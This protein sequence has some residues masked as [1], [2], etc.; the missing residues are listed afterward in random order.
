MLRVL[1][2]LLLSSALVAQEPAGEESSN[3]SGAASAGLIFVTGNN[4]STISSADLSTK[5]EVPGQRWIF[6]AKYAAVRQTDPVTS[7]ASTSSRLYRGAVEH[8]RFLDD[9][10]NLYLYGKGSAFRNVPTGLQVREDLGLGAGYTWRWKDGDAQFSL[11]GGPSALKENLVLLPAGDTALNGRA[12][13]GYENKISDDLKATFKA[14]FF[15][16]FDVSADRSA[17]A[18][19]KLRWQMTEAA[20]Y[21]EAGVAT[22]W[23]NT[24][25]PGFE[26]TDWIYT[27]Q[28]GTSW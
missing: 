12:A 20:W 22:A 10:N 14:E 8:H 2:F 26:K 4:E 18:E 13:C 15:Q 19:A 21:L 11:E 7:D 6:S 27:L 1:A 28:V 3:W 9:E 5:W 16:S 24:P 23:D 17:T 25:A